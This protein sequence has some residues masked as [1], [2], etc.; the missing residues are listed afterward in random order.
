MTSEVDKMFLVQSLTKFVGAWAG[1]NGFQLMPG[2]TPYV[3]AATAAVSTAA[4]GNMVAIAYTWSHPED[5]AQDGLL[6][7]G[8]ND[9]P[10]GAVAFWGDSWHQ[11]PQPTVLEGGFEEGVLSVSY[12]Y[13]GEW[14]WQISIDATHAASLMIR[15]DNIVPESAATEAVA[16]GA[17]P[18]MLTDLRRRS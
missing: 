16:A 4:T 5:G 6:V 8:R 15:M 9:E 12:E 14:R 7:V 2:E 18:A 10:T 1:S 13:G 11:S 17:Y 3:A